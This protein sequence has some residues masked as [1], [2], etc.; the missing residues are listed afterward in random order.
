M[1]KITKAVEN[2]RITNKPTPQHDS[3]LHSVDLWCNV[4]TQQPIM[5]LGVKTFQ[6]IFLNP[7]QFGHDHVWRMDL[8]GPGERLSVQYV[9]P[10][11]W[12]TH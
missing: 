6:Q 12:R 11:Y 3:S 8:W 9:S 10:L 2:Y 1:K 5:Q 4:Q 7:R